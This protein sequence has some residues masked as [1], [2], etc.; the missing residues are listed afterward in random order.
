M[1]LVTSS[2]AKDED[3]AGVSLSAKEKV[4]LAVSSYALFV[5]CAFAASVVV[6]VTVG[7]VV[8]ELIVKIEE[9]RAALALLSKNAPALVWT[10]IALSVFLLQISLCGALDNELP[11]QFSLSMSARANVDPSC[12]VVPLPAPSFNVN[13][14]VILSA[15]V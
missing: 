6:I 7:F 5:I 12:G 11:S 4:I 10:V 3:E 15:E 2:V 8:S 13:V 1:P 14:N 9:A